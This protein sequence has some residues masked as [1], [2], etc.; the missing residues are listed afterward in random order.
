MGGW[1]VVM[2]ALFRPAMWDLGALCGTGDFDAYAVC[3]VALGLI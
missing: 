2:L 1:W 3:D